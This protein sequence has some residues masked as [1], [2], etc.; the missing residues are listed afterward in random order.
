MRT[1]RPGRHAGGRAAQRLDASVL[2]LA[3]AD[4]EAASLDPILGFDTKCDGCHWS[5]CVLESVL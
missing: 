2:G 3:G 5:W 1:A 4:K